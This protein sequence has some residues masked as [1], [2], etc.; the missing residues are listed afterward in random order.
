MTN[1][2][3]IKEDD[4]V[5]CTVRRIEGTTIYLEIE[6]NGEGSMIIS[7][8][9]AGR[10]RNLRD[11][12]SP[13]K[14]IVCKVLKI[15]NNHVNLSLR[16]VTAKEKQEIL[17]YHDKEKTFKTILKSNLSNPDEIISKITEKYD[18]AEF[19][20]SARE[21]PNLMSEFLKKED[22]EKLSKILTEK[23]EKEKE[24]KS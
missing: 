23:K 6:G 18:L 14:K 5:L 9:A 15:I 1:K 13:N 24:A 8:V 2:N 22:A 12:V 16:R 10:I 7:E 17:E 11:Y 21:S 20:D 3:E 4:V 19:Y